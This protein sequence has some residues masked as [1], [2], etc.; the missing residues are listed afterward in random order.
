AVSQV[1]SITV[2]LFLLIVFLFIYPNNPTLAMQE[3]YVVG[4]YPAESKTTPFTLAASPSPRPIRNNTLNN[5]KNKNIAKNAQ[6]WLNNASHANALMLIDKNSIV[7]E[8]YKGLGKENSEFY[9]MSMSKSL[10]S[11][12]IGKALCNGEIRSLDAL[13]GDY[14]PELKENNNNLGK[15]TIKQLLTMSSGNWKTSYIGQPEIRGGMGLSTNG[16]PFL[17]SGWPMRLGQI[18]VSD[19][20]WGDVWKRAENKNFSEP[21]QIFTYTSGDTLALSKIIER[22][23]R[24]TTAQYFYETVWSDI[25]SE[26]QARW[27][28]DRD[29][30]TLANA[31][32]QA[33]LRDWGRL[34]IWILENYIKN[35]CFGQFLKESTK[36]QIKVTDS[37]VFK[38]YG[39]QWWTE[40]KLAP[41]FWAKGV[42][43]QAIGINPKT[44]KIIIKFSQDPDRGFYH[45]FKKWNE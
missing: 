23:T 41:G 25:G 36:A 26:N 11:L 33:T 38:G 42:G 21:G 5:P 29:G 45:L 16:K 2:Q 6:K 12:A 1:S 20:L 15:S 43:D 22:A 19:Y 13:A 10:T 3:K 18:T 44:S 30:S 7:F 32:F 4:G 8:G 28:S 24:K 14:V 39:Y 31:G 17:G 40:N 35:D 37:K 27:E 9:S 34:T